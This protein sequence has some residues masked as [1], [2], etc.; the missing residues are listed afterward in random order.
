MVTIVATTVYNSRTCNGIAWNRSI[1]FH[2]IFLLFHRDPS[3]VS[4]FQWQLWSK[5]DKSF[6]FFLSFS[7][8]RLFCTQILFQLFFSRRNNNFNSV[9]IKIIND[10]LIEKRND[11]SSSKLFIYYLIQIPSKIKQSL[12][13]CVL[14]F[15]TSFFKLRFTINYYVKN[16]T[17]RSYD[18]NSFRRCTMGMEPF[19]EW[20]YFHTR[21][22][23]ATAQYVASFIIS[24][25]LSN[26]FL[27]PLQKNNSTFRLAGEI[28][29]HYYSLPFITGRTRCN[30]A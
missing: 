25:F 21:C 10:R 4:T 20:K 18:R 26:V 8:F 17:R 12:L 14:D 16:S 5:L 24:K 30:M 1:L 15:A 9:S 3:S 23:R 27:P 28:L 2:S 11:R 6:Y 19:V 22:T 13:H 29:R 7:L